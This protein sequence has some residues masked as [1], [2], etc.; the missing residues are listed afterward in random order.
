ML[1]DEH[2]LGVAELVRVEGRDAVV[3]EYVD[4]VDLSDLVRAGPVPPRALAELMAVLGG[5][6]FR[7]HTAKAPSTGEP[8][9]VIHR[10][11]KP[12][13]VMLTARG[14]VRVLDFGVARARFASRESKTQGLV[15]GTLNYFPPEILAGYDP[16]CAVDIYGLGLTLWECGTGKHWGPPDVAQAKFEKKVE[17][18]LRDL[19]ASYRELIPVLRRMLAWDPASRPNGAEVE[20]ILLTASEGC[21]G[22]GLRSWAGEVVAPLLAERQRKSHAK[23]DDLVGR[24]IPI[25]GKD[26]PPPGPVSELVEEDERRVSVSP[27]V[28]VF[29]VS[30]V[31]GVLFGSLVL[32]GLLGAFI[33][34]GWM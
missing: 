25:D 27:I 33:Y 22:K 23:I 28:W 26:Q 21:Q 29:L 16:T 5:T 6:L 4:G 30:V 9:K 19:D 18:R 32:F 13:N 8:L 7:A 34:L 11:V 2:I 10:D 1:Q 15:L 3:M 12:A 24:T 31:V 14:G 17:L 20:Q